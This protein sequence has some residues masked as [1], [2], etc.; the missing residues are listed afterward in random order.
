MNLLMVPERW[1]TR[2][3]NFHHR[4]WSYY[5]PHRRRECIDFKNTYNTTGISFHI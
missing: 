4:I 2:S 1:C 3:F 5:W